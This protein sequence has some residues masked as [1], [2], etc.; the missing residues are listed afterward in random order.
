MSAGEPLGDVPGGPSVSAGLLSRGTWRAGDVRHE[1]VELPGGVRAP[2][3]ARRAIERYFAGELTRDV[4]ASVEL[5]ATE[6]VSN[7]VRHGGAG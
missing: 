7:A 2:E 4:L 5:L 1:R 6:L 3:S